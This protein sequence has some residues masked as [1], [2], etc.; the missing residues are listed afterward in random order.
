MVK[1]K[2]HPKADLF[3]ML[4]DE[5]LKELAADIKAVGLQQ[6]IVKDKN[7]ML[8]DG[9]NRLRACEIAKV[10][11]EFKTLNG[12]DA[13]AFIV[14]QNL[15]RRHLNPGQRA[16]VVAM[17]YPEAKRGGDRKSKSSSAAEHDL[18]P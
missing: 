18:F 2:I 9:R 5:E 7:G 12:V 6:P 10:K 4:S 14:S 13:E 17:M 8:V 3:P 1:L 16:M 11:P 15:A